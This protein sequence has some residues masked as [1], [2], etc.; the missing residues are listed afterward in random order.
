MIVAVT[1]GTGFIGKRLLAHHVNRGDTVRVLSRGQPTASAPGI[2]TFTGDLALPSVSLREFVEGADIVYHCAAELRDEKKMHDTN[3]RGTENLLAAAQGNVGRWV[4]L[5]STGVYGRRAR[6]GQDTQTSFEVT[7]ETTVH[8]EN[9]YE[10]SKEA[11]DRQVVDFA[12]RH[13]L[14]CVIV[15]PSN[16]YGTDMSNQSLF[17]LIR[18]ID[19]G[20]FFFIGSKGNAKDAVA[21]YVH[22][23][24]VV[25]ALAHCGTANLPGNAKAYIVSDFR[26]LRDFVGII[27]GALEKAPPRV[28]VPESLARLA[29]LLGGIVPGFPLTA[30]RIDALTDPTI[31]RTGRIETELGFKNR[32]SME[33]GIAELVHQWRTGLSRG[34]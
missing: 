19:R 33:N 11:A 30:S 10:I 5:S 34:E 24:N 27:S 6:N 28:T 9:A 2:R 15:R 32:T 13:N 8:P 1:G 12:G 3:L 26:R 7:E 29:A 31:Y 21:N 17:Q 25:D 22:V 20:M 18:M 4:Q 16:V 14:S 23:D